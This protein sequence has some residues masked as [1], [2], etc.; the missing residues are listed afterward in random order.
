MPEFNSA[1]AKEGHVFSTTLDIEIKFTLKIISLDE[2][3]VIAEYLKAWQV[4]DAE[5]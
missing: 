4:E 2:S 5:T 3:G 1:L